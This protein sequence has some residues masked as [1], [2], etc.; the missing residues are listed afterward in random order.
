MDLPFSRTPLG[1]CY[2]YF[3]FEQRHREDYEVPFEEYDDD[4]D[5]EET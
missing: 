3:Q 5:A 4:D 1:Y 2:Y